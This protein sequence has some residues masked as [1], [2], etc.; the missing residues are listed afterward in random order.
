MSTKP[1]EGLDPAVTHRVVTMEAECVE[2][3][4]MK[5]EGQVREYRI[6][7]DEGPSL[8]GEGKYPPPLAYFTTAVGF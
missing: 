1:P 4:Q 7:C 3:E 2:L 6:L 8:G 5:K